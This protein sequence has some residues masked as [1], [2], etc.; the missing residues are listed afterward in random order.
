MKKKV[1]GDARSAQGAGIYL[2]PDICRDRALSPAARIVLGQIRQ[3]AKEP[4]RCFAGNARLADDCGVSRNTVSTAVS[5]LEK[6]GLVKVAK[7]GDGRRTIT[8]VPESG[9]T[10]FGQLSES[11]TPAPEK[12]AGAPKN[13]EAP[14]QNLGGDLNDELNKNLRE[15]TKTEASSS[16]FKKNTT[17]ETVKGV[18]DDAVV[19]EWAAQASA[20]MCGRVWQRTRD[21][22]EDPVR[23]DVPAPAGASAQELA[24]LQELAQQVWPGCD[25]AAGVRQVLRAAAWTEARRNKL[26][27]YACLYGSGCLGARALLRI[28]GSE[29]PAGF[30]R[31]CA[32]GLPQPPEAVVPGTQEEAS[33]MRRLA[34][35]AIASWDLECWDPCWREAAGRCKAIGAPQELYMACAAHVHEKSGLEAP[36]PWIA[37]ALTPDDFL[38][39]MPLYSRDR[40][41]A[42]SGGLGRRGPDPKYMPRDYE[43]CVGF[44][45][46]Q[47]AAGGLTEFGSSSCLRCAATD[48]RITPE[49]AGLVG[50]GKRDA[51]DLAMLLERLADATASDIPPERGAACGIEEGAPPSYIRCAHGQPSGKVRL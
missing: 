35:S 28:G 9:A 47:A 27:Q 15:K 39:F 11:G 51:K 1:T 6:L 48:L 3:Y 36:L 7:G 40:R 34:Y 26:Q 31:E 22:S 12:R 44:R 21:G 16:V 38:E 42:W 19:R 17:P 46:A 14:A 49:L 8:A 45:V 2:G 33:R 18:A 30:A 5:M 4:A 50:D 13:C 43:N 41:N 10:G 29:D 20:M 25:P 37:C 32:E 24:R 23:L